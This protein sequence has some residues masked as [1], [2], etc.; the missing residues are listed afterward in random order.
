M[1]LQMSLE[2][3]TQRMVNL[4]NV[5]ARAAGGHYGPLRLATV[6]EMVGR[7]DLLEHVD[8]PISGARPVSARN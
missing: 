4:Y 1:S 6:H 5:L 8:Y 7:I 2:W 3:G